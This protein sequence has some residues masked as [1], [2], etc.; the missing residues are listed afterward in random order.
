MR[1]TAFVLTLAALGVF[2]AVGVALD[3]AAAARTVSA[4][5]ENLRRQ[6]EQSML[7]ARKHPKVFGAGVVPPSRDFSLKSLAQE[8]ATAR[9]VTIGYLTENDREADRGRRERQVLLRVTQAT[10]ANLVRFLQDLES[11]GAG[12][13]VKEIH[14]RPSRETPDTYEEAEIVLSRWAP[15]VEEK[16]P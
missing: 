7:M 2:A 10:H 6:L 13:R 14:A 5:R 1:S 3:R 4:D 16:K 9:G 12:A 8:A 11:Q 15:S